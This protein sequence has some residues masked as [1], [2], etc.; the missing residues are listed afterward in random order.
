MSD[1]FD[2]YR[3]W[4]S[5][6]DPERPPNY[7]RL[8][9]LEMFESDIE[10]VWP[11]AVLRMAKVLEYDPGPY[12]EDARRVF[13]E[14]ETA[15]QCLAAPD[16]KRAYDAGL[17]HKIDELSF[18]VVDPSSH[19]H[20]DFLGLDLPPAEPA[21]AGATA[22]T[23][24]SHRGSGAERTPMPRD[25][26]ATWRLREGSTSRHVHENS[27]KAHAPAPPRR[28]GR[29]ATDR[30]VLLAGLGIVAGVALVVLVFN[31]ITSEPPE[32][33][34]IPPLVAKLHS[35]EALERMKAAEGLSQLG[36]RAGPAVQDLVRVVRNDTNPD[37]RLSALRA[38]VDCGVSSDIVG[39]ELAVLI[40]FETD[41]T[42]RQM[43][44]NFVGGKP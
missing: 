17:K 12:C 40:P 24:P 19:T 3:E 11:A 37:V 7:Y 5:I 6:S 41:P 18:T 38:L 31:W 4:L 43:L 25:G 29:P 36:P 20:S 39:P 9:G 28:G 33:D 8:L 27:G 2:P 35:P 42:V 44:K 15:R 1:L 16:Q 10:K 26:S 22:T 23:K 32:V 34:P 13:D 14:L 21:M 30:R